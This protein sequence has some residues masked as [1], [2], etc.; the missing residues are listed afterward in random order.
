MNLSNVWDLRS[1]WEENRP[2][3]QPHRP[4]ALVCGFKMGRDWQEQGPCSSG[5][6]GK[7]PRQWEGTGEPEPSPS[8][9][10]GWDWR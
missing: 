1:V 4:P 6:R 8:R 9:A 10:W 5:K 7:E 2:R 3:L